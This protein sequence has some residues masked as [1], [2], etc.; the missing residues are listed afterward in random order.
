[1]RQPVYITD[2]I[3]VAQYRPRVIYHR[4]ASLP[5]ITAI[6]KRA[7]IT[8][9]SVTL[10]CLVNET[11]NRVINRGWTIH[12]WHC[13]VPHRGHSKSRTVRARLHC[14]RTYTV[15]ILREP[16]RATCVECTYACNVDNSGI[17]PTMSRARAALA[18]ACSIN[19]HMSLAHRNFSLGSVSSV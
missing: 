2:I 15:S 17:K 13:V 11:V 6:V 9:F 1:M 5:L 18:V 14:K 3:I 19:S 7:E 10:L 4:S 16:I 8:W 12:A